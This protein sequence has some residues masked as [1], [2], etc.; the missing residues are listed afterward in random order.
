MPK[1]AKTGRDAADV[2]ASVG[3]SVVMTVGAGDVGAMVGPYVGE[4]D[5]NGVE[6]VGRGE[7]VGAFVGVPVGASV[8]PLDGVIVGALVTI[9][10]GKEV[11]AVV[12]NGGYPI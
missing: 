10:V 8:G 5:G 9:L 2:T 1:R 6:V 4:F 11:G 12:L 7:R 3:L